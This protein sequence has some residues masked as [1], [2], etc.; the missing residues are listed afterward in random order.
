MS[1]SFSFCFCNES[2]VLVKEVQPISKIK[3]IGVYNLL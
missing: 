3:S 2:E 1:F